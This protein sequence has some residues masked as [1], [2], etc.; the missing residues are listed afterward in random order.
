MEEPRGF[1]IKGTVANHCFF[2]SGKP[3]GRRNR[4]HTLFFKYHYAKVTRK[5]PS[6][7][8][9][10]SLHPI[11]MAHLLSDEEIRA[12]MAMGEQDL[13]EY[14]TDAKKPVKYEHAYR[15]LMASNGQL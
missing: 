13:L 3:L 9:E 2:V 7:P 6:S 15:D 5:H 4:L 11:K 10:R 14:L 8:K 1:P 12:G